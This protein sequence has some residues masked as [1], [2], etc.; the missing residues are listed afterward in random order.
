VRKRM[1]RAGIIGLVGATLTAGAFTLPLWT[2]VKSAEAIVGRPATP[3]SVAGVARRSARHTV[4]RTAPR[5]VRRHAVAYGAAAA[6]TATAVAIGTRMAVLPAGCATVV[7]AGVTFHQ[8]GGAFYQ[9]V[10]QS[11]NVVYVVVEPPG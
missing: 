6:A 8:C 10:F 3:R 11:G 2:G 7:T 4:R 1:A 9:P 5:T